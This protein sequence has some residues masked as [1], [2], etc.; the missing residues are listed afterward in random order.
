MDLDI[1]P[2]GPTSSRLII[3]APVSE[4]DFEGTKRTTPSEMTGDVE[5]CLGTTSARVDGN[6]IVV[7]ATDGCGAPFGDAGVRWMGTAGPPATAPPLLLA[8]ERVAREANAVAPTTVNAI[9]R[10][11][12]LPEPDGDGGAADS[13]DGAGTAVMTAGGAPGSDADGTGTV[14]GLG[15]AGGSISILGSGAGAGASCAGR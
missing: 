2:G 10:G 5:D 11:S 1:E 3:I 13:G 6:R 4:P 8:G 15:A 7:F 9:R 14:P 12:T